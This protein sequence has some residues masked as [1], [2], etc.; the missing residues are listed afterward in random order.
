M[1][2]RGFIC[3]AQNTADVDYVRLAYLQRLSCKLTNPDIPYALIVD[4]STHDDMAGSEKLFDAVIKMPVDFSTNADWKQRNDWQLFRLSP[5]RE[6]I[7]LEADLLLTVN[8]DN[9]WR[10]LR[11]RPIV[12]SL[13]CRDWQG[14]PNRSRQYRRTFDINNL[15]DVYSGL[16]YWRYTSEAASYFR[17]LQQLS[18]HWDKVAAQLNSCDDPGSNDMIHAVASSMIGEHL[19]TLPA[20]DFFNITHMKSA[21]QALPNTKPWHEAC[22]VEITYPGIRINGIDQIYPFHYYDKQWPTEQMIKGYEHA[23]G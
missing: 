22:N 10:M 7:K 12:L 4:Q 16:M 6:N 19:T 17:L 3:V 13:G 23:I 11:K 1:I 2:D 5:F 20:A 21:V 8:I 15:P 9:W 14:N 18:E